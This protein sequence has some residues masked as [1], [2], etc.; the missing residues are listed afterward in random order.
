LVLAEEPTGTFEPERS[1]M[2]TITVPRSDVTSDEVTDALRHG[3]GSRYNVLPGTK[4]NC[5]NPVGGPRP[6]HPDTIVVGTGSTRLSRAQVRISHA[7]GETLLHV[8]PGGIG[9]LTLINRLWIVRTVRQVLRAAP[10]LR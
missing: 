4:V 1:V 6:D 8:S 2:F 5:W 10:S 7:T 9:L 3:L